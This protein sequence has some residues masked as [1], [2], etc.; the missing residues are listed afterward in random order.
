LEQR[1][2]EDDCDREQPPESHL[3]SA[4][5]TSSKVPSITLLTEKFSRASDAAMSL[6]SFRELGNVAV[7]GV[8]DDEGD[9]LLSVRSVCSQN[10]QCQNGC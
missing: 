1:A 8:A 7:G 4:R 3:S 2:S 9:A 10:D 6:A 5:L